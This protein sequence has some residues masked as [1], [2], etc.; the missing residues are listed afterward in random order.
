VLVDE[1]YWRSIINFEQF[2]A[3]GMADA[4]DLA[5]FRYAEDAEGIWQ[6]LLDQG[7]AVPKAR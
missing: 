4:Q 7:L 3:Q 2:V 5:L 6:A 1:A